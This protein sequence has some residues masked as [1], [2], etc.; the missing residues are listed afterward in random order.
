MY[1]FS[2]A[3]KRVSGSAMV[4]TVASLLASCDVPAGKPGNVP[5]EFY[6]DIPGYF[7]S[8]IQRL[9]TA[10]PM[11]EKTVR[12]DGLSESKTL[13]I[14]DWESELSGFAAVDLNKPAYGG[15]IVKDSAA[16]VVAYTFTKPDID[17]KKVEIR[18]DGQQPVAF[19]IHRRVKNALYET[20]EVLFYDRNEKYSLEKKQSVRVLGDKHY[21]IE[22]KFVF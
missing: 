22:G 13:Q 21:F 19:R 10:R 6:A 7:R 2:G 18:Y 16:N 11:V 14:A 15:Y 12:K 5:V 9:E 17:L 1:W 20:D 4:L 8:E 3:K